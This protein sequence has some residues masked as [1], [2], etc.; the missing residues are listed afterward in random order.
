MLFRSGQHAGDQAAA[1][2]AFLARLGAVWYGDVTKDIEVWEFADCEV[3]HYRAT[4][5]GRTVD[6][7]EFEAKHAEG[8]EHGGAVERGGHLSILTR[9]GG[10][11][12]PPE[13]SGGGKV[14]LY[15]ACGSNIRRPSLFI[16]THNA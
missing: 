11:A 15:G 8:V 10:P 4:G 13:H 1:V 16:S 9:R 14:R 3:V 6:C 5:G 12:C 7:V 2:E